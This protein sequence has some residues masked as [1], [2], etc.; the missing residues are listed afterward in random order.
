MDEIVKAALR[1][2][3]DVPH[4][5]GWLGLDAR[6]DWWLR[7]ARAQAAGPFPLSKG[8]RIEHEKLR[9]FIAR[10]YEHDERGCWFFQ[11]GPQRVFVELEAAPWVL[12]T[13]GFSAV[14]HTGQPLLV[15]ACFIDE[16]GRLFCATDRGLAVVHSQDMHAA[17]A[18]LD[19]G[20]WPA[21]EELV[22]E[23]MAARFGHRLSPTQG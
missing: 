19:A 6:G 14:S 20:A 17:L 23:A 5:Y 7:D 13:E 2:W 10:N 15:Q 11:N 21:P 16:H 8:S 12:R 1:K 4:A 3:P 22:F 18:A 9:E